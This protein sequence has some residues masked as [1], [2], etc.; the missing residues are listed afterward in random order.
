MKLTQKQNAFCHYYIETGSKSE[1]YARAYNTDKM[2][3]ETINRTAKELFNQPKI[4]AKIK[5]LQAA[6]EAKSDITKEEV[7]KELGGAI[8]AQITDF[9]EFDGAALTFKDLKTIPAHKVKAIKSIK[10]GQNG[11]ELV[12]V[13][14]LGAIDRAA[15]IMGW[16]EAEKHEISNGENGVLTVEYI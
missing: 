3:R 14:K 12:L 8:T 1:A 15:R 9:L 5:A 7:I 13:D 16:N 10:E 4:N 11:I 6:M 2:K